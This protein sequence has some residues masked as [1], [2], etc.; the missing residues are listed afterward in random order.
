MNDVNRALGDIRSIR[1]QIAHTTEF[2]GYGPMTLAATGAVALLAAAAQSVWLPLPTGHISRYI[3]L[4]I[5]TAAFSAAMIAVQTVTRSHR[6]HS[7][8]ADDMLRMAV[9][10]FLPCVGAGALL[11]IVL[12]HASPASSWMLPGLWQIV[13]SLG[14]F[15]SCR[16][17]PRH[18]VAVGAWYLLTGLCCFSLGDARALSPW[19]MGI[20]Y[21]V[22]Q[23]FAAG[24]L[25]F[26]AREANNE[27]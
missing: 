9:E 25:F 12:M 3:A 14:V 6:M 5:A 18:V 8:L 19:L 17:L 15:S 24:I 4:W 7:G 13:F 27:A 1:R 10:Q 23:I 20:P 16:F 26:Q 2:R 22:G 11:T 21:G